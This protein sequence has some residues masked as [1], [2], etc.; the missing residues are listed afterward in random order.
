MKGKPILTAC[1]GKEGRRGSVRMNEIAL[2]LDCRRVVGEW[3]LRAKGKS[4][5]N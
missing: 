3:W 4:Q 5:T 1:V 2:C